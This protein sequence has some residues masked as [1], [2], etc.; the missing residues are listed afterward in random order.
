MLVLHAPTAGAGRAPP[1]PPSMFCRH[2]CVRPRRLGNKGMHPWLP[3][4]Q[5]NAPKRRFVKYDV[6]SG[7]VGLGG[8]ER[9]ARGPSPPP[10]ACLGSVVGA[11]SPLLQPVT[12]TSC[13]VPTRGLHALVQAK[14]MAEGTAGTIA[15]VIGGLGGR[16]VLFYL[17]SSV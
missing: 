10:G 6:E 1:G 4:S 5:C 16:V 2:T 8:D 9:R 12:L 3:H 15:T 17:A 13:L 11:Q 14:G 7:K